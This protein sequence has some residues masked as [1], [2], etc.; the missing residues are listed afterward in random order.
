MEYKEG[1]K[2]NKV[3]KNFIYMIIYH[4]LTLIIPILTVPYLARVVG[5]EG[6]GEYSYTYSI[7]Y[8][9]MLF[10]LLG[11]N[12]YGNRRIAQVRDNKEELSKEFWSIY[13][14][15]L[16]LGILM[17]FFYV[18]YIFFFDSKYIIYSLI[19]VI[20]IISSILD[21]NWFFFGIEDFKATITRNTLV[22]VGSVVLIFLFVK[23][24]DDVWKYILIMASMTLLSQVLMWGFLRKKVSF[25]KV[26]FEEVK[27]HIKPD[28]ILF[29]P[30]IAVSLYKIMD[31]IMLG[32]I[33]T[34]SEVGYYEN[35]EKII[36][37][38]VTLITALGTVMLPRMSNVFATGNFDDAKD[39]IKK[40]MNFTMFLSLPVCFGLIVIGNNFAPIFFG[41]DFTKS[42][43]L[44]MLLGIT[45]PIVSFANVIRTQYLIPKERDKV[46]LISSFS[47]ALVNLIIN[48]MLI[49]HLES[50]GACIGTIIAEL[51]V[52]LYQVFNVRKELPISEYIISTLKF[53]IKVIIMFIIIYPF[54]FIHV[55]NKIIIISIQVIIGGLIYVLLNINYI[56]SLINFENILKKIKGC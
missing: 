34:V 49:P 18:G 43:I 2:M 9:F 27:K 10:T 50:V 16:I 45:I 20:F 48:A 41:E 24:Q 35:A 21:I 37:I 4:I 51:V 42:G 23:N 28:F 36:N 53:L 15:Q 17:I 25:Q 38:P 12:N 6:V 26:K 30:V 1:K 3:K 47:G 33:T 39:Y 11:V 56:K 55:S 54:N 5:A 13:I 44:I 19:E 14:I 32:R 7:V 22:K 40:S 52:M 46:Y 29:L 8:Y 31:K